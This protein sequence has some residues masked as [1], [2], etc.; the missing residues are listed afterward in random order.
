MYRQWLAVSD[1]AGVNPVMTPRVGCFRS[2]HHYVPSGPK[3]N[4]PAQTNLTLKHTSYDRSI[5]KSDENCAEYDISFRHRGRRHY[6][7]LIN[8]RPIFHS[9][10]V[11]SVAIQF[12]LYL[13]VIL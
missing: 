12:N 2:H 5:Q 4:D 1:S 13:S 8:L 3:I 9:N 10:N 11:S 6:P 7:K